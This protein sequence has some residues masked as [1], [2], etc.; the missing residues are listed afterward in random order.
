M[1]VADL[2]VVR[3]AEPSAVDRLVDDYLMA[4]RA[5][6]LSPNTLTNSYGF[7]LRSIFLPWCAERGVSDISGLNGRAVD[8]FSV[9][10]L[11]RRGKG[12]NPLSPAS[13][14]A[15]VRAIRGFL[16]WCAREGEQVTARPSLPKLQRRVI[17]VLDRGEVQT[18]VAAAPTERDRLILSVLADCGLRNA[19]L[20]TLEIGDV[21]RRDRQAFLNVHEKGG[22]RRLVPLP[23]ALLRGIERYERHTRSADTRTKR[24]FISL[25]RGRSGEYEALTRSGVLQLV[26]SAAER[27]RITKRV[28]PHL[29]RHSFV[30]NA[31]RG[32]MNPMLVAQIA[33]HRSL[34]MIERVYSHLNAD[35]AYNALVLLLQQD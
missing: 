9:F 4:C 32:G 11:D 7:P 31:L 16:N 20:C 27:A 28:Y 3:P 30:T 10:L 34:R 1:L 15:Y 26:R 25:R 22:G 29:L 23:P 18:L 5:K 19:E 21:L 35:D 33:G 14:H 2:T 13:V 8:A 6:G 17:D 24:L 12:G